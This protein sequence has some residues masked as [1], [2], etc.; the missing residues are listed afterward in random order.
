MK[1]VI[2][3]F[4]PMEVTHIVCYIGSGMLGTQINTGTFPSTLFFT[5]VNKA[6]MR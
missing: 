1:E 3:C 5:I 4:Q 6:E 2:V